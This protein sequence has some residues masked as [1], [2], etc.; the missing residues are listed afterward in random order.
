MLRKWE[1]RKFLGYPRDI[2][3]TIHK[4]SETFGNQQR[5]AFRGVYLM[6]RRKLQVLIVKTLET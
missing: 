3:I 6:R 4:Y 5:D 2:V 1:T